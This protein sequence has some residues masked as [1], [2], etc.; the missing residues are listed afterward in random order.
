MVNASPSSKACALFIMEVI[1]RVR[2]D[3]THGHRRAEP[4]CL[5][6]HLVAGR[7]SRR[8]LTN[9]CGVGVGFSRSQEVSCARISALGRKQTLGALAVH[10]PRVSAIVEMAGQFG[11][12]YITNESN[13]LWSVQESQPI[14]RQIQSVG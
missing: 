4:H 2:Y 14:R 12:L 3:R 9:F 7:K 11:L 8:R 6:D 10:R 1:D 5:C 13:V